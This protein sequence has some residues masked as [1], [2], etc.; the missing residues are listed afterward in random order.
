[1]RIS[2]PVRLWRLLVG[3]VLVSGVWVGLSAAPN[4]PPVLCVDGTDCVESP[5]PVVQPPPPPPSPDGEYTLADAT[6]GL[7]F[8]LNTPIPPNITSEATVTPS[9]IGSNKVNGRRIILQP[10]NYGNQT[11]G[12]QDQ[13]IVLQAGVVIGTL[14]FN[15]TARRLHFRGSP[16]RAHSIRTLTT[17]GSHNNPISDLLFDGINV[18]DG[19]SQ[20]QNNVHGTR[21]AVINSSIRQFSYAMGN[22]HDTTDFLLANSYVYTWG[23]TQANMRSHSAL[24]YVVVDSRLRKSG[25]GHHTLRVHGADSTSER[26]ADYI[27]VARNQMDG[28]RIAIRGTGTSGAEDGGVS[29]PSAGVGTVWFENNVLYQPGDNNASLYT[30]N[31]THDSD[32]PQMMYVR[33]NTLYTD[34]APWFSPGQPRSNWVVQ[35]NPVNPYQPPPATWDFQ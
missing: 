22:F 14:S 35:N 9:T 24:R 16:A 33:N 2:S 19:T 30:G 27:Y 31:N 26:P 5:E 18:D 3:I 15:N 34:R 23:G 21:V 8:T 11:F 32:R 1:M 4:P 20:G 28:A 7:P 13:E 25:S 17:G 6:A 29:G 10:G 12:T